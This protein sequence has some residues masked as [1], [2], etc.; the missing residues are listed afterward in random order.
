VKGNEMTE[1]KINSC[2]DGNIEVYSEENFSFLGLTLTVTVSVI[3]P[4]F[5]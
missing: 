5:I 2:T 1:E 4:D 3:L